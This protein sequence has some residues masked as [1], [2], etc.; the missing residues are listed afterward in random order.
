MKNIVKYSIV[1]STALGVLIG[2]GDESSSSSHEYEPSSS[3]RWNQITS[4]DVNYKIPLAA[5]STID[6]ANYT[7]AINSEVDYTLV[8][9]EQIGDRASCDQYQTKETQ[10]VF[11]MGSAQECYYQYTMQDVES[12]STSSAMLRVVAQ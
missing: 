6:L 1:V 7:Q 12:G 4:Q 8:G 11:E 2:C 9:F 3:P 5:A 10:V